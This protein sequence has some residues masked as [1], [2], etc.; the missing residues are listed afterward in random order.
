MQALSINNIVNTVNILVVMVHISK[1]GETDDIPVSKL[2]SILGGDK[3]YRN[4]KTS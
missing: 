4:N 3:C 2:H 1:W